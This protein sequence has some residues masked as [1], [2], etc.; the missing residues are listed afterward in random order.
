MASDL[1][2]SAGNGLQIGGFC[3]AAT[4]IIVSGN[5]SFEE[6]Q[7]AFQ[8]SKRAESGVMWWIGDLLNYGEKAYGETYSQAMDATDLS[9]DTVAQAKWVCGAVESCC[10]QQDLSFKHHVAVAPFEPKEQ[11]KW[12]AK[13]TKE[14]LS[15]ADLRSQIKEHKRQLALE[16]AGPIEQQPYRVVLA[17]PPWEYGDQRLGTVE[18][19]GAVAHYPT[20]PT[21]ELCSLADIDGKPIKELAAS[22]SVL[23]LWATAPC[24]TDAMQVIEAWGF[25]YKAQ[26]IWD[27]VRGFN[28][29]YNDVQHELLLIAVRGSCLPVPAPLRK[30]IVT[31]E[32]TKHSRKPDLFY[33]IIETMYPDGP[34]L[35]LFARNKR[36]GWFSWGNEA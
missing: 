14:G 33:E 30:S 10:R 7:A 11:K 25:D 17:D 13:A 27:K 36:E 20:M 18:G 29:H 23:F 32:K 3:L 12:L 24:L 22:E 5:P 1:V 28:G 34:R 19:G 6:W 21:V 26:F 9:Y 15:S 31:C 8:F 35:E 2:P 4:G 16:S